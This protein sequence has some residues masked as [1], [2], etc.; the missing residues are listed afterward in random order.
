MACHELE[1]FRA[2]NNMIDRRPNGQGFNFMS[3]VLQ[4]L[5]DI[6][7]IIYSLFVSLQFWYYW[8]IIKFVIFIHFLTGILSFTFSCSRLFKESILPVFIIHLN[9]NWEINIA[10][11]E[12]LWSETLTSGLLNQLLI[13]INISK[14]IYISTSCSKPTTSSTSFKT[15]AFL[16]HLVMVSDFT[17]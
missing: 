4:K 2:I 5:A 7:Q 17:C 11:N 9:T 6:L 13:F 15:P 10:T 14:R 1:F 8:A 16:K 3:F 12:L